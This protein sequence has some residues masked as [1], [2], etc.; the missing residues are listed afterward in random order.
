MPE[1]SPGSQTV[2]IP[3]R[4]RQVPGGE[5]VT[6]SGCS[7]MGPDFRQDDMGGWEGVPRLKPVVPDGRCGSPEPS[8]AGGYRP[9][10]EDHRH[11]QRKD[12]GRL[13]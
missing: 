7:G 1:L 13:R 3:G 10:A 2:P 11:S 5:A 9:H 8:G 6:R 12:Q 4:R